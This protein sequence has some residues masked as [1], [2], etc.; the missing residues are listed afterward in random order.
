MRQVIA[1]DDITPI[2]GNG[3]IARIDAGT[4]LNHHL[5]VVEV[6]LTDPTVA[7][8]EIHK[9]AVRRVFGTAV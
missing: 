7:R 2:A 3:G 1:D 4:D 9:A 6:E 5:Q 8:G